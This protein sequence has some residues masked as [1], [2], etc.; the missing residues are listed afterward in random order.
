MG[1]YIKSIKNDAS[2]PWIKSP[3]RMSSF[4]FQTPSGD[5][6]TRRGA[7]TSSSPSLPPCRSLLDSPRLVSKLS[8]NEEPETEKVITSPLPPVVN[9]DR[10]FS[11][12]SNLSIGSSR[13]RA[14][15]AS[16]FGSIS[17]R[18]GGGAIGSM[19]GVGISGHL[20][21]P[22]PDD[23]QYNTIPEVIENDDEL[24]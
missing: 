18:V 19:I 13:S 20:M 17:G 12:E 11:D 6:N 4:S 8:N 22:F 16:D 24:D 23:W 7:S 9:R 1:E 14:S 5:H 21:T 3:G 10:V 2:S 15:R